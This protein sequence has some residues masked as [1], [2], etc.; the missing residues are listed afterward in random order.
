MEFEILMSC[1]NQEDFANVLVVNQCGQDG[2]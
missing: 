2:W 1:M